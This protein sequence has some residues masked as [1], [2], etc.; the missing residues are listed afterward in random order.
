[1]K[2]NREDPFWNEASIHQTTYVWQL[3]HKGKAEMFVGLT[4]NR[5]Y[6]ISSLVPAQLGLVKFV[7]AV[8]QCLWRCKKFNSS[9]ARGYWQEKIQKLSSLGHTGEELLQIPKSGASLVL[10][11]CANSSAWQGKCNF[12]S[13]PGCPGEKNIIF[14]PEEF[15][16]DPAMPQ[17]IPPNG[18]SWKKYVTLFLP[19]CLPSFLCPNSLSPILY[20]PS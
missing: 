7:P 2:L 3:W 19:V 16:Q 11:K 6:P 9:F 17:H 5:F 13:S 10:P 18:V 14:R 1:M 4:T 12:N 15:S 8:L 20:Q